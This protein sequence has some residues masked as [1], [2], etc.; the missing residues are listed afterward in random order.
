MSPKQLVKMDVEA[1]MRRATE[2]LSDERAY[3]IATYNF[4]EFESNHS[5]LRGHAKGFYS[6]GAGNCMPCCFRLL[7]SGDVKDW[8]EGLQSAAHQGSIEA[9]CFFLNRLLSGIDGVTVLE[10]ILAE[11][12]MGC[13]AVMHAANENFTGFSGLTMRLLAHA[14]SFS[15]GEEASEVRMRNVRRV[16]NTADRSGYTPSLAAITMRNEHALAALVSMRAK[17][18]EKESKKKKKK[19]NEKK[20]KLPV[21]I[22]MQVSAVLADKNMTPRF[23]N[24]VRSIE[25]ST[26]DHAS[27]SFCGRPPASKE[28]R[29]AACSRCQRA[30]YCNAECQKADYKR[31]KYIC[32]AKVSKDVAWY[33][34]N[35]HVAQG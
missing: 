14:A 32:T 21:S 31:H 10:A 13:N 8:G 5:P 16:L 2:W 19:D 22:Q 18:Y 7:R 9:L 29:L 11:D 27:C 20:N 25:S 12:K 17:L 33:S 1:R 4:R 35:I 26:N 30:R 15:A 23:R 24:L 6:S 3:C 34:A 28:T